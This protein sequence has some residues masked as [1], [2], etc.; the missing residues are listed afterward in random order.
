METRA[1][2]NLGN[3]DLAQGRAEDPETLHEVA[4]ELR[5]LVHRLGQADERIRPL[6]I[7]TPHPRSDGERSHQED[8]GGLDGR[9]AACGTKLEDCQPRY[10]WIM[11]SSVCFELLHAGVLYSDLFAQELDL[12]P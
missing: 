1:G 11:G 7:E 3:L 8:P 10:G 12:L 4:D 5:E 2:Q 9:P 6:L